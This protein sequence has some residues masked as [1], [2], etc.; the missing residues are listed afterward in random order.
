MSGGVADHFDVCQITGGDVGGFEGGALIELHFEDEQ[1]AGVE[2]TF[3]ARGGEDSVV[4]VEAVEAAVEGEAG[5]VVADGRGEI[6]RLRR[7]ECRA[8]WRRSH[9]HHGGRGIAFRA[10]RTNRLRGK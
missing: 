1:A 7:W 9:R 2:V 10:G 5:F 8:D 4:E 3:C 6:R